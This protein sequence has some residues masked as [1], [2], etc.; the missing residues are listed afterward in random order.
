MQIVTFQKLTSK[1]YIYNLRRILKFGCFGLGLGCLTPRGCRD[2]R[3]RKGPIL[4]HLES[5]RGVLTVV[6]NRSTLYSRVENL[7][8]IQ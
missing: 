8:F 1:F 2:T 5:E 7:I 3:G 4:P 6:L